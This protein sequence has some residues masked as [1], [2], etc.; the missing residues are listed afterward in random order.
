MRDHS[1]GQAGGNET[2]WEVS[3]GIQV[4]NDA[5]LNLENGKGKR[6]GDG[7]EM[8]RE[9][10]PGDLVMD[11]TCGLNKKGECRIMPRCPA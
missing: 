7:Y 10:K 4:R 8:F 11:Y 9:E 5:S 3:P 2:S 1:Q 6:R